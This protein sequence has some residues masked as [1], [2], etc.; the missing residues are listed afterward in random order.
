MEPISSIKRLDKEA[1]V[2][3][4]AEVADKIGYGFVNRQF[5]VNEKRIAIE[6]FRLLV[7]DVEKMVRK[8]LSVRL[9]ETLEAPHDVII[10]LANDEKEVALPVLQNSYVLSEMDLIDITRKS[11]DIE[12]LS[13]IAGRDTV[14]RELSDALIEKSNSAVTGALVQNKSASIDENG[15]HK[16]YT[17]FSESV[18]MLESI[19]KRGALP[20]ALAEKLFM[21]VSDEVQKILQRQYNIAYQDAEDAASY[22]RELATLGLGDE[23]LPHMEMT[24]LVRHLHKN[25]RITPSIIVRALC[26]GNMRFFECAMAE[27]VDIPIANARI[28]IT[29]NGAGFE[30]FYR[31]TRLPAEMYPAIRYLLQAA[32][33]ETSLGRYQ[34]NDFRKR[35]LERIIK[36]NAAAKVEYMDY[37]VHIMQNN[38]V[39]NGAV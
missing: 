4:R 27:L 24:D 16:I 26:M 38:I 2:D 18:T 39:E 22:V 19:A 36:D 11:Q 21:S 5:N 6:I 1:T 17:S 23:A 31:K 30:A 28:L 12:I 37:I 34:R 8:A 35:M 14:S 10:K 7:N 3:V 25:G 33:I 20:V 9:A 32:L 13:T 29:D 15:L